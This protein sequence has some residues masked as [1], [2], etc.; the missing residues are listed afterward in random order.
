MGTDA[1]AG[2][3]AQRRRAIEAHAS[4]QETRRA[5]E[6][7]QA[8][9]LIA[10]F[11]KDAVERGLAPTALTA[12]VHRGRVRYRTTLR[13]WYLDR[14]RELAVDTDGRFYVLAVANSVR[15]RLTG[16]DVEPRPAPLVVGEGG[17][18][19]ES[20]P[21]RTLLQRRLDAKE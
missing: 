8:A 16:V 12:P 10:A 15:A 20:I 21:L 14:D 2:W 5:R 7:E 1:D 19:G 13:G 4:A 17:R 6:A 9:E 11:V 3:F 18:D